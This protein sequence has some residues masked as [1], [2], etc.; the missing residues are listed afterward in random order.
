MYLRTKLLPNQRYSVG[1]INFYYHYIDKK[2]SRTQ[3][4]FFYQFSTLNQVPILT[5]REPSLLLSSF[6]LPQFT[7][8][9][10]NPKSRQ[11]YS[12]VLVFQVTRNNP[13]SPPSFLPLLSF[14][15]FNYCGRR[16]EEGGTPRVLSRRVFSLY[17]TE[18]LITLSDPGSHPLSSTKKL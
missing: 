7:L 5:W 13:S 3:I 15:F 8:C 17:F 2:G 4:F 18:G 1:Q 14:S 10:E 12:T 6:C 11:L 16:I 9:S